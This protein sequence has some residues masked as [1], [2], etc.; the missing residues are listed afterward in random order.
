MHIDQTIPLK[1]AATEIGDERFVFAGDDKHPPMHQRDALA[2]LPWQISSNQLVVA[3]YAMTFDITKPWKE[4]EYQITFD[5]LPD[6]TVFQMSDFSDPITGQSIKPRC[7]ESKGVLNVWVPV[8][9]YPR[10]LKINFHH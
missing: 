2:I 8:T 3:V 6:G 10:L 9:D 7:V 4:Q 1:I 5:K